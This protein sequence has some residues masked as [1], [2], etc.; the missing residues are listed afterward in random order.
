MTR[1]NSDFFAPTVV[2][3]QLA[4]PKGKILGPV[5]KGSA[6][7]NRSRR[8]QGIVEAVTAAIVIVPIALCL[9]DFLVVIIGNSMND[10]TCKN[11]ARAAAN[12]PDG[13]SAGLAAEKAVLAVHSPLLNSITLL[14]LDYVTNVSVTAH[15]RVSIHLPVP[16]PGYSDLIFDAEDT[17]P[18]VGAT[19]NP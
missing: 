13:A 5:F 4:K 8:G 19:P 16:F 6:M 17:E 15:T 2:P 11:A 12:Q 18:I 10:T 7:R 1:I 14:P 3:V 9:F